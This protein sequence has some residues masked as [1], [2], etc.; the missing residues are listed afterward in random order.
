MNR[1]MTQKL[2]GIA[3]I[4]VSSVIMATAQVN[5]DKAVDFTLTDVTGKTHQLYKYLDAEKYV[6]LNLTLMG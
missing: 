5:V 6:V 4:L 3:G 2:T 1:L